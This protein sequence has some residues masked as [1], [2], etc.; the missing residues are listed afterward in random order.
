MPDR[1]GSTLRK[2]ILEKQAENLAAKQPPGPPAPGL[3]TK[4]LEQR[5]RAVLKRKLRASKDTAT[6]KS[7]APIEPKWLEEV[8]RR[9]LRRQ[10]GGRSGHLKED[11]KKES[12]YDRDLLHKLVRDGIQRWVAGSNQQANE[13]ESHLSANQQELLEARVRQEVLRALGHAPHSEP[14]RAENVEFDR[15]LLETRIRDEIARQLPR[16]GVGRSNVARGPEPPAAVLEE[17][18][19]AGQIKAVI[20][21]CLQELEP[22]A[23]ALSDGDIDAIIQNGLRSL[24][25]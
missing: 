19:L 15:D 9:E 21:R 23:R 13:V 22:S 3:D 16:M 11:D 1:K 14:S 24:G 2:R 6:V 8:I 10:L 12:Q 18:I 20:K 5:I 7:P 25:R 4:L 17:A